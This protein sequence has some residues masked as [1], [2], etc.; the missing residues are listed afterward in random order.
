MSGKITV[1]APNEPDPLPR[2]HNGWGKSKRKFDGPGAVKTEMARLYRRCAA[3]HLDP[4]DLKSAIWSLK[5]IAD[6]AERAE[7]EAKIEALE[8]KLEEAIADGR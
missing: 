8:A 4:D 2:L 7:L 6:T 3:G 5:Q 1:L